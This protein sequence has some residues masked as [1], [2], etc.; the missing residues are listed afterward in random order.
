MHETCRACP[1]RLMRGRRRR[2]SASGIG[3]A[4]QRRGRRARRCTEADRHRRPR[5]TWRAGCV[6]GIPATH[7]SPRDTSGARGT[8][9]DPRRGSAV[10]SSTT[11][12]SAVVSRLIARIA[13]ARAESLGTRA[14]PR[15]VRHSAGGV[16]QRVHGL[17]NRQTERKFDC[18]GQSST[19]LDFRQF[20]RRER[21]R[22]ERRRFELPTP[23]LR[24]WCSTD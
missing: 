16:H 3:R 21:R 23:T 11:A 19:S 4:A 24:T 2:A 6:A 9:V 17:T 12:R 22:V 5:R 1:A 15:S 20:R 18:G 10:G 7:S 8:G 13:R 14:L